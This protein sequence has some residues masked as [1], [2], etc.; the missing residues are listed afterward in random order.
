VRQFRDARDCRLDRA[1]P[2]AGFHKGQLS[3]KIVKKLWKTFGTEGIIIEKFSINL[4]L[5]I[6]ESVENVKIS[7][8]Y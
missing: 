8:S 7:D 1:I 4:R 6:F 5:P 3:T 2:Q